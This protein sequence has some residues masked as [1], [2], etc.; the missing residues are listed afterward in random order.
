MKVTK[1]MAPGWFQPED[2]D[3]EFR[4]RPL[5]GL[6]QM[7]VA[8][9][10]VVPENGDLICTPQACIAA[11][12]GG[13]L[14]WKDITDD[15]DDELTFSSANLLRLDAAHLIPVGR[16]ILRRTFITE[17]EKKTS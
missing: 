1:R 13:L 8:D 2:C 7:E 9:L 11:L 3:A 16:E 12:R 15:A 17:E 14:D 4:I 10:I 5:N 6:E